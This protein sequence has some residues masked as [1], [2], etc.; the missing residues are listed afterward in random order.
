MPLSSLFHESTVRV[1]GKALGLFMSK[2]QG[3]PKG[4]A[5]GYGD[6]E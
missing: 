6:D 4:G 3:Q 1:E 5:E 2:Q